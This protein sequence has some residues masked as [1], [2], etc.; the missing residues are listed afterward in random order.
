MTDKFI[1][2]KQYY[3]HIYFVRPNQIILFIVTILIASSS[4]IF[5]CRTLL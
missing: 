2:Y 3:V 1:K 4:V 5:Y